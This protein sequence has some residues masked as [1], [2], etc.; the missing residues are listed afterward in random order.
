MLELE[1]GNIIKII[2]ELLDGN[3]IQILKL[4][5]CSSE[6][7]LLIGSLIKNI[8][9]PNISDKTVV[10]DQTVISCIIKDLQYQDIM[11]QKLEH[12]ETIDDMLLKELKQR[13]TGNGG[14]VFSSVIPE[15]TSLNIAQLKLI[16]DEYKLII[17][18]IQKNLQKLEAHQIEATSVNVSKN[19]EHNQLTNTLIMDIIER[20]DLISQLSLKYNFK[21]KKDVK[22]VVLKLINVYTMQSERDVFNQTFERE[23]NNCQ[24]NQFENNQENNIEFF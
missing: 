23:I 21:R 18:N 14:I 17:D 8:P 2:I 4:Q 16:L 22:G 19:L 15:I 6:Y 12:I 24:D 20:H 11:R 9:L 10:V 7:F 1:E 3:K 13:T 5:K